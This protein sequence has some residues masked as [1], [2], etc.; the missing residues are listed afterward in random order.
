MKFAFD[1][2]QFVSTL[3]SV[4]WTLDSF[5]IS[6]S[7]PFPSAKID[8]TTTPMVSLLR[9]QDG[10]LRCETVGNEMSVKRKMAI[11]KLSHSF[12]RKLRYRKSDTAQNPNLSPSLLR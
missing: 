5:Q 2:A 12:E 6:L 7:I 11:A 10:R 9:N 4:S 3:L 1:H 8:A